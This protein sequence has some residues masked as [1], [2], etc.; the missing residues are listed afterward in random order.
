L[1]CRAANEGTVTW[2][3]R[4]VNILPAGIKDSSKFKVQSSKLTTKERQF[5]SLP[6]NNG[7]GCFK[8]CPPGLRAGFRFQ[9]Q[10]QRQ[11]PVPHCLFPVPA[12]A[13]GFFPPNPSS[14]FSAFSAVKGSPP[15][16]PLHPAAVP[17]VCFPGLSRRAGIPASFSESRIP[18]PESRLPLLPFKIRDT[19]DLCEKFHERKCFCKSGTYVKGD[20]SKTAPGGAKRYQVPIKNSKK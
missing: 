20:P 2:R 19:S 7:N 13:V 8:A 10:S 11:F 18:A 5:Q 3:D 4:L 15:A 14:A 17:R 9:V 6:V 16:L 1:P 12:V